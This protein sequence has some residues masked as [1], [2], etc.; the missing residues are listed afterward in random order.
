MAFFFLPFIMKCHEKQLD[1]STQRDL[2][3]KAKLG[4]AKPESRTLL[5]ILFKNVFSSSG[6]ITGI[7]LLG[8]GQ[9]KYL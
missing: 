9:S 8:I 1:V 3:G 4:R 7:N 6:H 2:L 5:E